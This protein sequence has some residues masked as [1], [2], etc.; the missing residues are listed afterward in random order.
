MTLRNGYSANVALTLKVGDQELALSHVGPGE[1]SLRELAKSI[2]P[3]NAQIVIRV[4]ENS[5]VMD[6]Y[7]P[8]GVPS[9]S[10]EVAYF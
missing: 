9:N 4:D 7:L 6:I 5:D 1:V 10:Y 3:S 2:E 8:N